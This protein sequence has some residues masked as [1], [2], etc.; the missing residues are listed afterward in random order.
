[1]DAI[2]QPPGLPYGDYHYE[3]FM[4]RFEQ[5]IASTVPLEIARWPGDYSYNGTYY[6]AD[7][8]ERI[9]SLFIEPRRVHLFI[10]HNI[11]RFTGEANLD[12][13]AGIP[14]T[15]TAGLVIDF[16]AIEVDPASGNQDQE[17][18]ELVNSNDEAVDI[19]NWS[20]TGAV[21]QRFTPGTVIPAAT[22]GPVASSPSAGA[23]S[24]VCSSGCRC[25]T[26]TA[27]SRSSGAT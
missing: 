19:S 24:Y 25:A 4:D 5:R 27:P 13:C 23:A 15:Q 20:L 1:M 6:P 3:A 7:Q 26:S 16:G 18:I 21:E 14:H 22:P 12:F 9:K 10:T 17:Y 2:L 8:L 11:D